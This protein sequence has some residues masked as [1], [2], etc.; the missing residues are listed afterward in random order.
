MKSRG[1]RFIYLVRLPHEPPEAMGLKVLVEGAERKIPVL[2]WVG[3]ELVIES[4]FRILRPQL[5]AVEL[6]TRDEG[7]IRWRA[8]VPES[9]EELRWPP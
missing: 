9:V 6:A 1:E 4:N 8:V 3:R 5:L 7:V 2:K